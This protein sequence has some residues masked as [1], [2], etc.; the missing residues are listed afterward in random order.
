M[1]YASQLALLNEAIVEE[2]YGAMLPTIKHTRTH[3]ISA[4]TRLGVYV[5]GYMERLL[6]AVL[7]DY[8]ALT[9]YLGTARMNDIVRAHVQ[10]NPSLHWDL[11]RYPIS[12]SAC[13]TNTSE[14]RAAIAVAQLES[15]IA[16]VFWMPESAPLNAET[17]ATLSMEQL[18]ATHFK[19]RVALRLLKLD[20][21]ANAFLQAFRDGEPPTAIAAEEEYLCVVRHENDVRRIVLE[22][23][24]Y[25]LLHVMFSGVRFDRALD[26]INDPALTEKLPRYL[27][28][29]LKHGLF[30][31]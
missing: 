30:V 9:H 14:D 27:A 26:S 25:T 10:K 18:S 11:N 24:E 19:P 16:D 1:S 29:W 21:A 3:E 15:T 7:A 22:P 2:C 12:F 17:L 13:F 23:T 5:N 31:A 4:E 28:R 8:P 20:C 6:K